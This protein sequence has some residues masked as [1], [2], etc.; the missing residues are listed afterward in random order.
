MDVY[1]STVAGDPRDPPLMRMQM[2][3]PHLSKSH[4]K[5]VC[6]KFR[7]GRILLT[8]LKPTEII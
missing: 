6:R 3:Y 8:R 7:H 5:W 2:E 1:V 4:N